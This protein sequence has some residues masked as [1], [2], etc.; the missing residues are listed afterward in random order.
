MSN[1]IRLPLAMDSFKKLGKAWICHSIPLSLSF[2]I[3]LQNG[4]NMHLLSTSSGRRRRRRKRRREF[5][6]G[7]MQNWISILDHPKRGEGN[8]ERLRRIPPKI[9]YR[10]RIK[11]GPQSFVASVAYHLCPALPAAFTQPGA[12]LLAE[13]CR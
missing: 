11:G 1:R 12:S 4:R 2:T 10:A 9:I 5:V 8:R 6:S 13:P 3:T 7:K